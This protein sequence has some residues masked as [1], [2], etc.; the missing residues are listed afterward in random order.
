MYVDV[1]FIGDMRFPGG[2][3]TSIASEARALADAGYRVGLLSLATGP[4][5]GQ[6][7]I[8]PDIR[9]LADKGLATFV[10]PQQPVTAELALLHHP[11]AFQKLPAVP[12]LVTS[13]RCLIVVHHPAT[14]A[15]GVAQYDVAKVAALVAALFGPAEWAPV[16]PKVR[17][18]LERLATPPPII[19][20]DWVNVID[21]QEWAPS[22]PGK[23]PRLRPVIGRHSRPEPEKWPDD[24]DSF[25]AAYPDAPDLDVRLM[26]YSSALDTVVG[27]KP[28]NWEV[29]PFAALPVRDFLQTLDYFSYFHGSNWIEAFGRSILEAMASGLVCL[30]P[31]D[32]S[33]LF[34]DAAVYCAP[35]EVAAH[36]RRLERD[37]AAKAGLLAAARRLLAEEYGP[38]VAVARVAAL[39]GPPRARVAASVS[40]RPRILYF[41]SNGV[42]MGHLARCLASARR[43]KSSVEPVVVTMSKAFGVARDEGFAVEYIAY[44]RSLDISHA[45]WS[46]K[47]A[48]ELDATLDYHDPDVFVFD[49]NVPYD[50][51]MEI[52]QARPQMWKV[53]QRRPL[54]RPQTGLENLKRS[55]AFDVVIEPGEIAAPVDRGLTVDRNDC[56]L[57]VPPVRFLDTE[58]ALSRSAARAILGLDPDRTAVL[59]QLGSGNNFDLGVAARMVFDLSAPEGTLSN[60]QVVF[61]RWR[62][63]ET[64]AKLPAHVRALE[65][66]PIA[67]YL[68]AFDLAIASAG[69]N[70]FHENI[71]AGLP[72]LFLANDHPEQD[73]QW[74]RANYAALR[75]LALQARANDVHSIRRGFEALLRPEVR[76]RVST[77]CALAAPQNGAT[78]TARFLEDLAMTRKASA[79]PFRVLPKE[80]T[81]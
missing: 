14:D 58:E 72:T 13:H 10:P 48:A 39:I 7:P 15:A 68:A 37:P 78:S 67:R 6:R 49:G 53:W 79:L 23:L 46:S 52:L 33:D 40:C 4:L 57:R 38:A 8:H 3:S 59:L 9:A 12:L 25:L 76:A 80:A 22:G 63:T 65:T 11:A 43:L 28:A 2:T 31:P 44:F 18:T 24:R 69:Y 61:A 16:G 71:A 34:K 41:T 21:P 1:L 77:A 51:L 55:T 35:D 66:F 32:F 20:E 50:G 75:G 73:E 45:E 56:L 81:G 70:T 36:V 17:R 64:D 19:A 29:L 60:L 42:G 74:L 62:I 47:F 27:Q 54:W 5:S 30:L 26:G